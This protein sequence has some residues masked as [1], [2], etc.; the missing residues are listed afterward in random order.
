MNLSISVIVSSY[1]QHN[2]KA[3]SYSRLFDQ[4]KSWLNIF[5]S[6]SSYTGFMSSIFLTRVASSTSRAHIV[7]SFFPESYIVSLGS[8]WFTA[9]YNKLAAAIYDGLNLR[10][11]E[12][13]SIFL[14]SSW[15]STAI[16][17]CCLLSWSKSRLKR[18][19]NRSK[20]AIGEMCWTSKF[21]L[22]STSCSSLKKSFFITL[23]PY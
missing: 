23:R 7:I 15:A 21:S 10:N 13:R 1:L 18:R 19:F 17:I 12:W 22:T 11:S 3:V 9:A 14:Q 20:K 8:L 2:F 4:F 6:S 5:A 16:L